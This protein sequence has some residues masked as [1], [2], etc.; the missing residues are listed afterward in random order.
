M[1]NLNLIIGNNIKDLRKANGLTQEEL[2]KKLNYSNKAISRWESGEV[3]PDV[4]TLNR[5][6]EIFN[7]PIANIFEEKVTQTKVEHLYRYRLRNELAISLLA[8]MLVWLIATVSYVYAVITFNVNAWIIFLWAVPVT[9]IVGI[10]FN[11]IWGKMWFNFILISTLVWTLLTSIYITFNQYHFWLIFTIGIPI[12]IGIVLW[13]NI[14]KSNSS[15]YAKKERV[16]KEKIKK[17]KKDR[18]QEK[19][20]N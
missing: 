15:D 13:S 16:K 8:I 7:I 11:S 1:E 10:V 2:A 17:G 3:V 14:H 4:E 20:P 5:L 19:T 12:Q 18:E 9:C 6:C